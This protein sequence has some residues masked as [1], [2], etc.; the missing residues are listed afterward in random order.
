LQM[1][2]AG[3]VGKI[4]EAKSIHPIVDRQGS[5]P[6]ATDM[7]V[8]IEQCSGH[9][10]CQAEG[11]LCCS[12]GCGHVCM[13]P[14]AR[15]FPPKPQAQACC[16]SYSPKCLACKKGISVKEFCA[17]Q[18]MHGCP[19][20]PKNQL[21]SW[22]CCKAY[23]PTCLSCSKGVN[24]EEFCAQQP[25]DGCPNK[26]NPVSPNVPIETHQACPKPAGAGICLE[27]CSNHSDCQAEGRLCCS[28]GCGHVCMAPLA[29]P[30][31][32]QHSFPSLRITSP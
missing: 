10:D 14:A 12:N 28:N 23:T 27:Q 24:I 3:N 31:P 6:K 17:R 9:S 2:H 7:G 1:D 19:K 4:P 16:K 26:P 5:C 20:R 32:E 15:L 22:A 30:E 13:A 18:P 21:P 25:M 11:K 29:K 8:C